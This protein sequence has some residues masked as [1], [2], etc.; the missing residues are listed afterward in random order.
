MVNEKKSTWNSII[1]VMLSFQINNVYILTRVNKCSLQTYS[2]MPPPPPPP[3]PPAPLRIY[4][5]SFSI[6]STLHVSWDFIYIL[7]CP[8]KL[9]TKLFSLF[10]SCCSWCVSVWTWIY[11]LGPLDAVLLYLH[12]LLQVA[13][14]RN[15][16]AQG[17]E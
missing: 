5:F 11:A 12:H 17:V 8:I 10:L 1:L 4:I 13:Q 3:P 6:F 14:S 9:I 2:R 15:S 7:T 16:D